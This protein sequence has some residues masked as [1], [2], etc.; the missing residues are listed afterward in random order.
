MRI[1]DLELFVAVAEHGSQQ[2]A[3]EARGLSQSALSKAMARLEAEAGL[4]LFERAAKGLALTRAG[5]GMLAHAR[6]VLQSMQGLRSA[7]AARA[8]CAWAPSRF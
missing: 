5:E 1:D 3:A 6:A 8:R 7:P 2:R 4:A